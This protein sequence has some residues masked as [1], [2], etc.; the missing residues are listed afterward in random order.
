MVRWDVLGFGSADV[1]AAVSSCLAEHA[2]LT[3]RAE[4]E[5][6]IHGDAWGGNCVVTPS[7]AVLMDFERTSQGPP[8]WDLACI[9]V[10]YETFGSISKEGYGRFCEAYGCDVMSWVGYPTLRGIRGLRKVTFALQIADE[11]PQAVAQA[12]YR[13]ARVRGLHGPRPWGWSAVA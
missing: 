9:A 2:P 12:R 6:L 5:C 4:Q 3:D 11:N 7:G 8:E 13:I 10:D 1:E